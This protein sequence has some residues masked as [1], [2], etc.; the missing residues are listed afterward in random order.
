MK[1]KSVRP[2]GVQE[3]CRRLKIQ[4]EDLNE[5]MEVEST[6]PVEEK[7]RRVRLMEQLK[8]QL[9]ELSR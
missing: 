7:S 3:L 5:T 9:N 6:L 2:N 8:Q 4:L 1:S